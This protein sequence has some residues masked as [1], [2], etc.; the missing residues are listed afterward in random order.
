MIFQLP[1]LPYKFSAL[2]PFLSEAQVKEHYLKHHGEYVKKLNEMMEKKPE[3]A[4]EDVILQAAKRPSLYKTQLPAKESTND[5]FNFSAQ[6]YNHQL[7]WKSLKPQGSAP[8][9]AMAEMI[10][11]A[12]GSMDGINAAIIDQG[13]TLFGSGYVWVVLDNIDDKKLKV[14]RSKDAWMPF[15]YDYTTLLC[16]DVWEH[17]YYLDYKSNKKKYLKNIVKALNWDFAEQALQFAGI[18]KD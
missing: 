18:S 2:E 6:V 11:E 12:Y 8:N 17:A 9:E 16:I 7:Y 15:V 5:L 10:A 13:T 14:I 3:L 1:P 4:L